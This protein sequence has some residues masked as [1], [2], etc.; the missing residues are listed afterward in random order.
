MW[1]I[2]SETR[3][4]EY[5]TDERQERYAILS[6]TWEEGEVTFQDM[7]SDLAR[8]KQGYQKIKYTCEEALS[9][10]IPYAWV[11]TCCINKQS[12]AE[13][14]EAINSMFSYYKEAEICYIYLSDGPKYISAEPPR[15]VS[16]GKSHYEATTYVDDLEDCR[17]FTRGWT[18]QE[19]LAPSNLH[20]FGP[21]WSFIADKSSLR[22]ALRVITGIDEAA[23][24]DFAAFDK[25]GAFSVA[26]KMSWSAHR[27]TTREEDRAYSLLGIFDVN[28]PLI[29]GERDKAFRRLQEEITRTS[30]D[31]SIFA[32]HHH[33][34]ADAKAGDLMASS[35]DNFAE[36]STVVAF[37]RT[38]SLHHPQLSNQALGL[39]ARMIELPNPNGEDP[40]S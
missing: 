28:I 25:Q 32:W 34:N 40:V 37:D 7:Q 33:S 38:K 20:F 1:L 17:W 23:I 24:D 12:S 14:S 36:L 15:V 21:E 22:V 19:L 9:H 30:S 29:Y 4:L 26:Q 8:D 18:L 13:L 6:H 2:N 35:P 16:H 27:T 10:G 5:F 3:R 39:Q 31:Q 11:D